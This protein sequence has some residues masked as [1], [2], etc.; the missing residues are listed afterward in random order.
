MPIEASQKSAALAGAWASF[1][2]VPT[3]SWLDLHKNTMPVASSNVLWLIAALVF[4][5]V[6]GYMF[7]IG[8]SSAPF[9]RLWFLEPEERAR[10]AVVA[11]RMFVWFVSAGATGV[12]WSLVLGFAAKAA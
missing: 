6:P 4:F 9:S 3:E 7:V 5:L 2:L 11:K 10:Y 12:L 8:S 1:G